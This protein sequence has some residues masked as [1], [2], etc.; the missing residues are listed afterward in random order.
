[1]SNLTLR[2]LSACIMLAVGLTALT[3]HEV[4]RWA[5]VT[6][7][8]ALGAWELARMLDIRFATP[9]LALFAGA[10]VA[11]FCVLQFP[12]SAS[13]SSS[14]I[15]PLA[16]QL[17]SETVYLATWAWVIV[18]GM[19]YTLAGFRWVGI[20]SLAPW[21]FMN[22]FGLMYLGPWGSGL[23]ALL[24]Q[25]LGWSGIYPVMVA[26]TGIA[27]TDIGAY[28][29][30]RA[31]GKHKLCPQISSKKTVEGAIGGTCIGA[32]AS[33]ALAVF[34]LHWGL[35]KALILGL[36]IALSSVVGDLFISVLKRYTGIKDAS[37]LIPGHGGI[38]DRFDSLI[39]TG[40]IAAFG[41]RLLTGS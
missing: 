31:F 23:F 35:P 9:P 30:G 26:Y 12:V 1:M 2:I 27:L 38:L 21:L 18:G 28:A 13:L 36:M 17:N 8:L 29:T 16:S 24:K 4:S 3:A 41:M 39:F 6:A 20:E 40:P 11:L 15:A 22:L 32:S 37:H 5:L 25:P 14:E 34:L 33:A 19:V 7:I 10:W